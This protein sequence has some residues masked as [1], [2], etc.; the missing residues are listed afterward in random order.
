MWQEN[1]AELW[2]E[3]RASQMDEFIK[4]V[5]KLPWTKKT[6]NEVENTGTD[7]DF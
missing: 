3:R 6:K 7:D 5:K 4:I 1:W 2:P